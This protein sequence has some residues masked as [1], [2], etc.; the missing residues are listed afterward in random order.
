M[1]KLLRILRWVGTVLMLLLLVGL[2]LRIAKAFFGLAVLV[3]IG[4]LLWVLFG[5]S[6]KKKGGRST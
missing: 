6:A 4:V 2:G 1:D 5:T 3:G